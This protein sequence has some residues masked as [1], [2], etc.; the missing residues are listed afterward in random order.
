[1]KTLRMLVAVLFVA[2][3]VVGSSAL[4]VFSRVDTG[5]TAELGTRIFRY[6]LDLADP[7]IFASGTTFWVSVIND[8]S[9]GVDP[10]DDWVWILSPVGSP[11]ETWS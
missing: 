10:D 3:V 9:G 8:T 7:Q 1:M 4:T 11:S 5:L 2:I 6:E